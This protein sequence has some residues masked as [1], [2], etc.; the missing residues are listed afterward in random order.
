MRLA[1]PSGKLLGV[2]QVRVGARTFALPVQSLAFDRDGSA[3]AGG[4]FMEGDQLGILVD[5][6]RPDVDDQIQRATEDAVRH[7]SLKFLN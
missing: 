6:S 5:A 4:F 7:L 1:T 3:P 2:V